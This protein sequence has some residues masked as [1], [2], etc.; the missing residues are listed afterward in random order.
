MKFAAGT[1]TATATAS[2]P[3]SLVPDDDADPLS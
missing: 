3:R 2:A 1:A